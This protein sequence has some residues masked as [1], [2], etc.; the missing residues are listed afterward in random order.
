METRTTSPATR[1]TRALTA[2]FGGAASLTAVLGLVGLYAGLPLLASLY[3]G[4][5]TI[6]FSAALC[7]I[8]LGGSLVFLASR[9]LTRRAELLGGIL[10][11]VMGT[12]EALELVAALQ[13]GTSVI[14]ALSVRTGDA[15]LGTPTTS[16]SPIASGL[17][18]LS[19]LALLLLLVSGRSPG[20]RFPLRG[21]A[22]AVGGV[23]AIISITF[24]VSY[25]V[26]S[27]LLY[28]TGYIPIAFVSALA[29]F[30]V[31]CGLVTAAGPDAYPLSRL[32]GPSTRAR[33]LR[34]FL[35]LTLLVITG[36]LALHT[37]LS[38]YFGVQDA[39]QLA[40]SYVLFALVTTAV[41]S[42]SA[43]G[44]G[45]A[46]DR[47]RRRRREVE[48]E[49]IEKNRSLQQLNEELTA[50]EEE[51]IANLEE[52]TRSGQTLRES[53]ERYRNLFESMDEGFASCEMIYEDGRAVDFRFLTV[54]PAFARQSGLRVDEVVGRRV[55]EA[56]PGIESSWIETY[57]R[58]VDTGRSERI[59]NPV[60]TLGRLFDVFVWRSGPGRFGVVFTDV[61]ERRSIEEALRESERR[62]RD[63]FE[64]NHAVMLIVD[65]V[66]GRI[67]DANAGACT[68]YGYSREEFERM[69]ITD[70]NAADPAVTRGYMSLA[71]ESQ[72]SVFNF[73]HRKKDGEIRD[74]E[75]FSSP[76]MLDGHRY[77]HS[78]VQDETERKRAERALHL[79]NRRLSMLSSITRHDIRNQLTVLSG[80]LELS[81]EK[82][83]DPAL[84]DYIRKECR[85]VE[86][87][88]RQIEFTQYYDSIGVKAPEW[89]DVRGLILG[90]ESLLFQLQEVET[91]I[92]IPPLQV[93]AD[94][95]IGKVF[96]NLI[97]NSLRH[98]GGV[99]RIVFSFRETEAG[100][101]LVYEDDGTGIALEDKPR[102]F[103]K[104]V[105][106][107]TGLGLFLSREIL[108]ITGLEIRETGEPGQGARF[109]I[110]VPKGA[111]RL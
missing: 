78:I 22:G 106:K 34:A 51:L 4:Y 75:V 30:F 55:T 71:A 111:Y 26:G 40:L 45:D 77:L 8:L 66:D 68:Y 41:V 98:G 62:Y 107:N 57:A 84:Q 14:E 21:T 33:L 105:G 23:V 69:T 7:W 61:T 81:K 28:G 99:T 87:I 76:I 43:K 93:Y 90:A 108:A 95:L 80:Y 6:A 27:P 59:A 65:P 92:E 85:A 102:L 86:T 5:K 20:G 47:E 24:A 100:G 37:T 44:L 2:G 63:I 46:L 38:M 70:I 11:L 19:A 31:G 18:M 73:R 25:I 35:P 101:V 29:G 48:T 74:V 82:A 39:V 97:E 60:A 52:L 96:Y 79:A 56:I 67:R 88:A 94:A 53:E 104:D 9:P 17:I 72:G 91:R 36:V 110:L 16:I 83:G 3:P 1:T 103:E 54:N 89:Q 15:L 109:E 49:L 58:V 32:T 42:R 12:V 10:F 50:A 13:G 64:I